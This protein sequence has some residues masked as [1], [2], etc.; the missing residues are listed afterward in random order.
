VRKPTS[1]VLRGGDDGNIVPL[2]RPFKRGR[3]FGTILVDLVRHT[4][5]DLL[6]ERSSQST[7]DWMRRHP[8]I[9]YVS[10]DRGKDY[11]KVQVEDKLCRFRKEGLPLFAV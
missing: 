7:A 1:T 11:A 6:A 2:T 9:A 3:K 10:R 4:V 8:E 5:I